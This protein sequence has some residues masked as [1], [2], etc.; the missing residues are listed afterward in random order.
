MEVLHDY[1]PRKEHF[2]GLSF[3]DQ[4]WADS[5]TMVM[6]PTATFTEDDMMERLLALLLAG[7]PRGF[8]SPD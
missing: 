2:F 3:G 5:A 7:A 6:S 8:A 1:S 4:R